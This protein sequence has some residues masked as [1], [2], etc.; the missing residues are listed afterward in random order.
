MRKLYFR[1]RGTAMKAGILTLYYENRNPGGQ[2]QARALVRAIENVPG[3]SAEQLPFAYSA[4]VSGKGGRGAA[5]F[6]YS[7][8]AESGSGVAVVKISRCVPPS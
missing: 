5:F 6:G 4:P 7:P 1:K 8:A 2:L 3:W